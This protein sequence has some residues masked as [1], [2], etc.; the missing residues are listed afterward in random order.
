MKKEKAFDF[1]KLRAMDGLAVERVELGKEELSLFLA[2]RGG[3]EYIALADGLDASVEVANWTAPT[4]ADRG[5][6][7][8]LQPVLES[9]A[10][11]LTMGG[12]W[13]ELADAIHKMRSLVSVGL[14]YPGW[15]YHSCVPDESGR[16]Q[17]VFVSTKDKGENTPVVIWAEGRRPGP[18]TTLGKVVAAMRRAN[19]AEEEAA[20]WWDEEDGPTESAEEELP[21]RHGPEAPRLTDRSSEV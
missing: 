18:F 17:H 6:C 21:H 13:P 7:D 9:I 16:R 11:Y 1:D 19:A 3:G 14:V 8:R 20:D 12:S 4:P 10:L 5:A 2:A 15:Y